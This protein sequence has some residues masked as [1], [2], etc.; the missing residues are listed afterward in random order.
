V[1]LHVSSLR[2][3]ARD[4]FRRPARRAGAVGEPRSRRKTAFTGRA[5]ILAVVLA[6]LVIYGGYVR[7]VIAKGHSA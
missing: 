7:Y 4:R 2:A 6:A 1:N 3:R 5:A